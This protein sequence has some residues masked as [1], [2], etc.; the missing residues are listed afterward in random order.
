MAIYAVLALAVLILA[1]ALFG[2]IA[3]IRLRDEIAA[4]ES[5][6]SRRVYL[7]QGRFAELSATVQQLEFER[8]NARGEIRFTPDMTL[9]DAYAV[10]PRVREVFAAF[11]LTGQ[12]CSSGAAAPPDTQTIAEA[13]RSASLDPNA[14]LQALDRFR[15]DPT[16]PIRTSPQAARLYRIESLPPSR[17]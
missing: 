12:G 11:G 8:R 13:C 2:H 4:A 16:G 6:L 1:W 17:N 5:R 14:V 10:H 15:E 7:L 9:G 3:R